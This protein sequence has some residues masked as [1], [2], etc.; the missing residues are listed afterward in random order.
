MNI[1]TPYPTNI[2]INNVN[3]T[4]ESARRDNQLREVIAKPTA[5]GAGAAERGVASEHDKARPGQQNANNF[6]TNLKNA[7]DQQK[8][9]ERGQ[10]RQ[11]SDQDKE[12]QS[13]EQQ[14]QKQVADAEKQVAQQDQVKIR[15][16]KTRDTEVRAHEAAHAAVG[17]QFAGSPTYSFKRGP[18]GTNYAVGGEVSISTSAAGDPQATIAKMQ[19][20][21]SAA[22]APAQPSGQ[23]RKVA[24]S[25]TAQLTE[26][27]GAQ[28]KETADE[29][30]AKAQDTAQKQEVKAAEE[31]ESAKK[32]ADE[33][34]LSL[35]SNGG[36][37]KNTIA[38]NGRSSTNANT[39]FGE[40]FGVS[41]RGNGAS[42]S[43][44]GPGFIPASDDSRDDQ[45]VA[46]ASRV[47][48]FYQASTKPHQSGFSQFA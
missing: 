14:A 33:N 5:S 28:I 43:Q 22:L 48:N 13:K 31:A 24:A 46:R 20:V 45:V 10:G 42:Q 3:I 21:R 7:E 19:Q 32:V 1:V 38:I 47:Q 35:A 36:D 2:P 40:V 11:G 26:A 12:Q 16:L 29:A 4:T 34:K 41:G 39:A 15:E 37:D 6:E 9:E 25:A 30:K 27:K 44:V 18:D 8:I 17:G 23:D